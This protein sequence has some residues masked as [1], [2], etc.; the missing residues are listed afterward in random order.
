MNIRHSI[1]KLGPNKLIMPGIILAC[2]PVV[3]V[4][5]TIIFP[6]MQSY[7]LYFLPFGVAGAV[8]A[9]I[10]LFQIKRGG[11]THNERNLALI[12][13]FLALS[14]VLYFCGLFTYQ[15]LYP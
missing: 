12:T 5:F 7:L 14:P 4:P 1:N 10:A 2:I 13:Y 3:V 6:S 11:G 9:R 8:V 15:L